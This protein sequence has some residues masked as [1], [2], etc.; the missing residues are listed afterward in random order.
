MN[1]IPICL[2]QEVDRMQKVLSTTRNTLT[3]LKM[4]IEGT[5][6]MSEN[7]QDAF[8]ALFNAKV[9]D[10]WV[11]S[12][13]Q[14]STIGFWFTELL[15]RHIQYS[16]WLFKQRPVCFWITGFFNPQGFLT[17]MRQEVTRNHDGWALDEVILH[18]EMTRHNRE[19]LRT[20]PA[21]GIYIYGLF[22]DGAGWDRRNNRLDEQT[23]KNLYVNLPV[24]WMFAVNK[25]QQRKNAWRNCIGRLSTENRG[26]RIC[27]SFV[28]SILGL[29]RR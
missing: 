27:S 9:P 17:A 5:I 7:L 21:E 14:S 2:K 26:A 13:W 12:S 1:S 28:K 11:K 4:A 29:T 23:P 25:H 24:V 16:D 20:P 3:D 15:D 6:I 8:D 19:D 22:I 18:N 10:F